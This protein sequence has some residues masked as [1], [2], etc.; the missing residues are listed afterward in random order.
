MLGGPR[1]YQEEGNLEEVSA[2]V[3]REF[4]SLK[5][6]YLQKVCKYAGGVTYL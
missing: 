2:S 3:H 6:V 1:F 4:E 5:E